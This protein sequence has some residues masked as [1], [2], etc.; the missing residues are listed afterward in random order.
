MESYEEGMEKTLITTVGK[1]VEVEIV[2]SW[3]YIEGWV[4]G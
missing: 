3:R 2:R 4:G 1:Y